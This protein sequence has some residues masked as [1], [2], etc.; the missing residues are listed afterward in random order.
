MWPCYFVGASA[1]GAADAAIA[2][3]AAAASVENT[4]AA[5]AAVKNLQAVGIRTRD[6]ANADRCA[7]NE[8]HS[9]PNF[10]LVHPLK[11]QPLFLGQCRKPEI[12][13]LRLYAVVHNYRKPEGTYSMYS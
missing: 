5:E 9:S 4:A 7:T 11:T 3:E 13:K 2:A 6:S 1:A 12:L 8:L 10:T